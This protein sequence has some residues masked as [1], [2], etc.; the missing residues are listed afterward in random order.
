MGIFQS[1]PEEPT[2]WAGLPSEPWEERTPGETLPPPLDPLDVLRAGGGS[3]AIDLTGV[4][5][6]TVAETIEDADGDGD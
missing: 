3:I 5:V 2:E 1:R 6:E 4:S